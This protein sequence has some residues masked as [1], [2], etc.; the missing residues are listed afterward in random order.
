MAF[1]QTGYTKSGSSSA[2]EVAAT[3]AVLMPCCS[4]NLSPMFQIDC[5][6]ALCMTQQLGAAL[7]ALW[8]ASGVFR[9]G[10][11]PSRDR[12]ATNKKMA[13]CPVTQGRG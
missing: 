1:N 5:V 12:Y 3:K 2:K 11:E 9:N 13:V 7:R 4:Q 10:V 6:L 8:Y